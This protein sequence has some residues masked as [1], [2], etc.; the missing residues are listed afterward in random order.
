MQARV[1]NVTCHIIHK[2]L[3]RLLHHLTRSERLGRLELG[4]VFTLLMPLLGFPLDI[5]VVMT[6]V[7]HQRTSRNWTHN[8]VPSPQSQ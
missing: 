6:K 4:V 5:I 8:Q 2:I 1:T 7:Y 3:L